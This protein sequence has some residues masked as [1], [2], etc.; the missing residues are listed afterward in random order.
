MRKI[1]LFFQYR[2]TNY[3]FKKEVKA[4]LL[5]L[6]NKAVFQSSDTIIAVKHYEVHAGRIT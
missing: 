5:P 3:R 1:N 4:G 6:F 2:I